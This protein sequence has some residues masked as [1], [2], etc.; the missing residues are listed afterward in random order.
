MGFNLAV[1]E[2]AIHYKPSFITAFLYDL[3]RAYNAFYA[4]CPVGS[5][6][7]DIKATRL[8]LSQATAQSLA[9]GLKLLGIEAPLRM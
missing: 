2:A 5:A 4:E 1:Q 8:A 9:Q 3:A 6:E 7:G